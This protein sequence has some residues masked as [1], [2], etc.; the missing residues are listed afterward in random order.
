[1]KKEHSKKRSLL[2]LLLASLIVALVSSSFAQKLT[3]LTH[4][5]F[6]ISEEVIEAFTNET[7]IE[8]EFI[9]GGDAGETLNRAILTK[10]NP[11]A[12]LLYGVDNSLYARAVSEGI[13]EAYQSPALDSID[14]RYAFDS[15]NFVTPIDAGYV[16]FNL[17]KAYFAAENLALPT[18]ISD[19][20]AKAYAGLT[21]TQNPAT[22]SPGLAF[23]LATVKRFGETGDYTWLN[24]WADLRD[25]DLQIV[26]GWS[27]AYYTS[28]SI[29]GGDR[30]IVLS[31]ASS[32]AAEV[33]FAEA[34]LDDAPTANL[35]CQDCV[36][37]QI[38][39]V[40]ILKGSKNQEAAQSFIDYMLSNAFQEDIAPNMFVYPVV[41]GTSLPA[42]FGLYSQ[43]PNDN[44]TATLEPELIESNLTT[45]LSQWTQVVEQ[46][47][48][49]EDVD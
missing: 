9:A 27:D 40:G 41:T 28:F 16:N 14:P 29:Y 2:R 24:Y 44:Q 10:N 38:E 17:D 48:N 25:N 47:R 12:D 26:S 1:M 19:L 35:F 36:F 43:I 15:E 31:Y 21:V 7:G 33:I 34:P 30:P 8:L 45:W 20:S 37:E 4:D 46:G 32:P 3:V 5:S 6:V 39:A 18:D 13:F 23:M 49:P 11:L 42:E 22:S